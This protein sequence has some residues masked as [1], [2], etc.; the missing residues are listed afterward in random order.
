MNPLLDE[1]S[2]QKEFELSIQIRNEESNLDFELMAMAMR[3]EI[4]L[5][6]SV[7]IMMEALDVESDDD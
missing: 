7:R 6:W 1:F 2:Q 3:E 5:F 4:D